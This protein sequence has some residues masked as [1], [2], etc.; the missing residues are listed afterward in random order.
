MD[1]C[2][3]NL[4]HDYL[5]Q[6]KVCVTGRLFSMTHAELAELTQALGGTFLRYPTRSSFLLLIGDDGWPAENDGSPSQILDRAQKLRA[7]GYRI[8][9]VTEE[10]FLEEVGLTEP[11]GAIR[12]QHTIS[13]LARM[14]NVT[15][16]RLRHW[17]RIG[18]I[19]PVQS[20]N[21]LAYFDFHQVAF[22]KRL[23]EL[24]DGG[25]SL[26][27]IRDGIERVRSWFPEEKLCLDQL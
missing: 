12:G 19:Q 6:R 27:A 18:L 26:G 13:D 25:A 5:R 21:R 17:L 4:N 3:G 22:A 11:A 23:C 15:S 20:T 1:E 24:L 10:E 16:V 14:L 8:D 7:Y 2:A 9:F